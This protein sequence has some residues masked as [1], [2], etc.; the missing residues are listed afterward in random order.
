M[1]GWWLKKNKKSVPLLENMSE[2]NLLFFQCWVF[3]HLLP[4]C[5]K[6]ERGQPPL[7]MQQRSVCE[8][9]WLALVSLLGSCSGL[10]QECGN[11][12]LFWTTGMS[13]R[14]TCTCL[15]VSRVIRANSFSYR[16]ITAPFPK[17][18]SEHTLCKAVL[19]R[20]SSLSQARSLRFKS[21]PTLL[22]LLFYFVLSIS[23][24]SAVLTFFSRCDNPV[25][26]GK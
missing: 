24:V 22:S 26:W 11:W 13:N 7:N 21:M 1:G 8:L 3:L 12:D 5:R 19:S 2:K 9:P 16:H 4:S 15:R 20:S 10:G 25:L 18:T 14:K 6:P 23:H 17:M